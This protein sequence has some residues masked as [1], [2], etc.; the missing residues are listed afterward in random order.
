MNEYRLF[1][2]ENHINLFILLSKLV[3]LLYQKTFQLFKLLVLK[4]KVQKSCQ[5]QK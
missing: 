2:L 5:N 3:L 4:L 1:K